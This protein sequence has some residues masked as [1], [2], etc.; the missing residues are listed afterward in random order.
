[1][2]ICKFNIGTELRQCF[3]TALRQSLA[4]QPTEFDRIKLLSPTET[5]LVEAARKVLREMKGIGS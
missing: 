5:P 3:G 1:T 2:P 4:D